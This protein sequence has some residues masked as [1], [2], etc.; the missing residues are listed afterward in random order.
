[1][2]KSLDILRE[3]IDI[4][5]E[6]GIKHYANAGLTICYPGEP[7]ED[8]FSREHPEF[9]TDSILRYKFPETR[10]YAA[11]I[12]KEFIEWGCDGVSIDCMRYPWHNTEE[13]LNAFFDA[14]CAVID[15]KIPLAV[16]IPYEDVTYY[17]VAERL[18]KSGRLQCV[19]PSNDSQAVKLSLK[20]YLRFQKYG[21]KVYGRI[22][23]WNCG[24]W[25]DSL[26]GY[27]SLLNNPKAIKR[28][29]SDFF[30]EGA[31][32]IFVYQ[33]DQYVADAIVRLSLDWRQWS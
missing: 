2:A 4:C 12:V 17:R 29:I 14:I 26:G 24:L 1:M 20:P 19:I 28:D 27:A 32:G 3:S 5:R 18:A 21:C 8:K 16:R 7:C 30:E 33:G 6:L 10:A 11:A 9:R 31:D 23:G 15:K 22:D 13:E 25:W